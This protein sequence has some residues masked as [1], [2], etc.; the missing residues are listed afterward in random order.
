MDEAL[1]APRFTY[2]IICYDASGKEKWREH[3][4]NLVMTGG[5]ND[6]LDKYFAG[7]SYTAAWFV[8]LKGA[9]TIAA[10]DTLS[11]H[12]GW[13]ELTPYTGSRQTISWLSASGGSKSANSASFSINANATL[14]GAF[15]ASSSSGTSG[16]LYSAS[17]FSQTRTVQSGD[18]QTVALTVSV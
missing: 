2:D 7:S 10:S 1:K 8:G 5:R 15:V 4:S 12:A 14:A 11:S 17:D 13:S 9:G 3:I 18:T 6:L 16:V